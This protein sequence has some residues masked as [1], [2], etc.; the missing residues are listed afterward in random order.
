MRSRY[1]AYA[2]NKP[3][4]LIHTT[5]PEN[6]QYEQDFSVWRR[7]ISDFAKNTLF[8]GL[9]ILDFSEENE[10]GIVTF[11]AHLSQQGKDVSF[12]ERSKFKRVDWK[13]L[14]IKGLNIPF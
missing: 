9:D 13:W 5:H 12:T 11:T 10:T 8:L 3:D 2:L 4:Y 1:S 14:Y 7:Q 6:E